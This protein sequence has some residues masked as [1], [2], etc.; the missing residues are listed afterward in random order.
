MIFEPSMFPIRYKYHECTLTLTLQQADIG[1]WYSVDLE[2]TNLWFTC[3]EEYPD[4]L[5]GATGVAG[6]HG[7]I[8]VRIWFE[9][10]RNMTNDGVTA[11]EISDGGIGGGTEGGGLSDDG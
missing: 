7:G 6:L 8:F 11:R 10:E 1:D 5:R 3:Q 4:T 2:V 9:S